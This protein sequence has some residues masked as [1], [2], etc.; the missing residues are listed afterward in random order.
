MYYAFYVAKTVKKKNHFF[1]TVS[2]PFYVRVFGTVI[3]TNHSAY[4]VHESDW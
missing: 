3:P 1:L 2:Q 4:A